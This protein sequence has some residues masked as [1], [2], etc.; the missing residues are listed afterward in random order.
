MFK[1]A[2]YFPFEFICLPLPLQLTYHSVFQNWEEKN[3]RGVKCSVVSLLFSQR[4]ALH[5]TVI[6]QT[7]DRT[8]K[9]QCVWIKG[10]QWISLVCRRPAQVLHINYILLEIEP[11][12]CWGPKE[13]TN[14]VQ[15]FTPDHKFYPYSLC[16]WKE[17][18]SPCE[19]PRVI[20]AWWRWWVPSPA[21]ICTERQGKE[22]CWV[23]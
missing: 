6:I 19:R 11:E 4:K 22:S 16:P 1:H 9:K 20:P 3:S 5:C 2:L 17:L 18:T 23:Q 21:G 10:K 15:A 8:C 7:R 14:F 12:I 13:R